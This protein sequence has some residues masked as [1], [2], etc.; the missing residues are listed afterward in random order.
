MLRW[1]GVTKKKLCRKW[2]PDPG[3]QDFHKNG[4]IAKIDI[5]RNWVRGENDRAAPAL[6]PF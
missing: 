2:I 5:T 6:N 3:K 1:G 4:K